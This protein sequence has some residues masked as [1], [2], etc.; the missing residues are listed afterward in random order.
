MYYIRNPDIVSVTRGGNSSTSSFLNS[1]LR[2]VFRSL[3]DLH[4]AAISLTILNKETVFSTTV[5]A[6]TNTCPDAEP[7]DELTPSQLVSLILDPDMT[8]ESSVPIDLHA[9]KMLQRAQCE[10][11]VLDGS[12]PESVLT[13]VRTGEFEGSKINPDQNDQK[14]DCRRET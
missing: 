5:S 9:A 6:D 4:V 11:S 14:N 13:A 1:I 10:T 2:S 7:F 12:D 8:A 3:I